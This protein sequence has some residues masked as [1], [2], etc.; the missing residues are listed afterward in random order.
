[1]IVLVVGSI[2]IK[3]TSQTRLR[4]K[5]KETGIDDEFVGGRLT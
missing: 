5:S 1:M 4:I 3:I 2:N